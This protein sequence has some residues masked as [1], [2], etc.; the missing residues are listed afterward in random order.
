MENSSLSGHCPTLK[1]DW[2]GNPHLK[3]CLTAK[4]IKI[5]KEEEKMIINT[6]L[7]A[8]DECLASSAISAESKKHLTALREQMATAR[9]T[10]KP[11]KQQVDNKAMKA[12][13]EKEVAFGI[14]YTANDLNEM[15]TR[16]GFAT[17]THRTLG[18]AGDLGVK[19][20]SATFIDTD[21]KKRSL[22]RRS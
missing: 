6:H 3:K 12:V 5:Q 21:G 1:N 22:Y 9:A 13:L 14:D 4:S 8:L 11:T 18:L 15:L 19:K 16:N 10:R 7:D 20:Q 2:D 17:T